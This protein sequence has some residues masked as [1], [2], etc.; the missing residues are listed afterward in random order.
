VTKQTDKSVAPTADDWRRAIDVFKRYRAFDSRVFRQ[1]A[2][3]FVPALEHEAER[4]YDTAARMERLEPVDLSA[5]DGPAVILRLKMKAYAAQL[6]LA[7]LDL[8][9]LDPIEPWLDHADPY[10]VIP[11]V[12]APLTMF[13]S[14][15]P[16]DLAQIARRHADHV[17]RWGLGLTTKQRPVRLLR[18]QAERLLEGARRVQGCID[19]Y[20]R[21]HEAIK[22]ATSV[23]LYD[24]F[25]AVEPW[26]VDTIAIARQIVG[27][28]I[29]PGRVKEHEDHKEVVTRPIAARERAALTKKWS[30]TLR[31]R[32]A[33]WRDWMRAKQ[34]S[35]PRKD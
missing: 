9:R 21:Q 23:A 15:G 16:E 26:D 34:H 24:L 20:E 27:A 18:L 3:E 6:G 13:H 31:Q 25:A 32:R 17:E 19:H 4:A 33:E 30:A 22:P 1:Q 28:D 2:I 14:V 8:L 11:D 7:D 12:P 5:H 10:G 29:R 35:R